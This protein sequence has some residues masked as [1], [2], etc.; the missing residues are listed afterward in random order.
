MLIEDFL[1]QGFCLL[2]RIFALMNMFDLSR[3]GI[4]KFN[5]FSKQNKKKI[6]LKN[7][8]ELEKCVLLF[9]KQD[10]NFR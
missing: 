1:N 4:H 10:S 7:A 9:N 6:E 2:P 3:L 5:L 8:L